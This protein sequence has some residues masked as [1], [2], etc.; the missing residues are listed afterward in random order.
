LTE[1]TIL[2]NGY[3]KAHGLLAGFVYFYLKKPSVA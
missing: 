2:L 1:I 3:T